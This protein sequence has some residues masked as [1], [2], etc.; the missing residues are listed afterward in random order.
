MSWTVLKPDYFC[1]EFKFYRFCIIC[2]YAE[3]RIR[4]PDLNVVRPDADPGKG[5]ILIQIRI[6]I[7][8]IL[9]I[10]SVSMQNRKACLICV[11]GVP[12]KSADPFYLGRFFIVNFLSGFH[13]KIHM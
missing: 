2:V 3:F 8:S 12:K 10:E 6:E 1:F 5:Q 11:Q 4:D 13:Q 7:L 9:R